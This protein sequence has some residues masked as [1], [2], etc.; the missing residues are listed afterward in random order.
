MMFDKVHKDVVDF[1]EHMFNYKTID[2]FT[3]HFSKPF[4][5][6]YDHGKVR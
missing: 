5:I 1:D 3:E 6:R 4:K 2:E